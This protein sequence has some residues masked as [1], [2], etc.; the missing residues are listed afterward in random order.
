MKSRTTARFRQAYESLPPHIKRRAK[1]AFK[2]FQKDP[3]HSSLRF[4]QVH[5]T[6]PVFSA[7]AS[8]DYRVLGVRSDDL[9]VWFWIGSHSDYDKLISRL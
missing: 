5:P 1:A 3:H 7:R 6:K 4:K 9:I 2:Q 8:L